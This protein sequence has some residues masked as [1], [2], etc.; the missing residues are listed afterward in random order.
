MPQMH[1][2]LT[3]TLHTRLRLRAGLE[4]RSLTA[5]IIHMLETTLPDL[6]ADPNE[7]PKS[8]IARISY[9]RRH[10]MTGE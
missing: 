3:N 8:G 5:E 4:H 9:M 6:P 1:L 10:G 2:K 7:M